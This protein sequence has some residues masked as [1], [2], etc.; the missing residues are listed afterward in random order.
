M[1]FQNSNYLV[2]TDWLQEHLHDPDLRILDCTVYLPNYFE[3]SS[4]RKVEIVPGREDYERGHIPGS[5][6]VDLVSELTD[7]NNKRF[8]FPM[9]SVTQFA[10]TMSR[11]GVGEGTRV[12]LYDRML[13]IWA[14]RVWWMLR[15]FGFENAAVLNGGWKKW[16]LEGR[17]ASTEPATYSAARFVPAPHPEL[18]AT[19]EEVLAAV[20]TQ[21]TCIVNALDAD[22]YAGR[23]PVKYGR[24]GHIPSSV[25]VS[26]LGVVDPSTSAYLPED[27]LRRKFTSVGALGKERVITYCGGGIAASS[28]AFVLTRLGAKNVAVYDGSMT[29]WGV[30]PSLPL[31]TGDAVLGQQVGAP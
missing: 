7:L 11:H 5:A 19:K 25:N 30:D 9:P 12:V 20:G 31:E 14:A 3:E 29:E 13:N 4:G 26:F 23:G 21:Q 1:S 16:T 10:E 15:A 17:P 27:E 18:I 24:P 8:M 6:Y 28:D 22:E 2:E